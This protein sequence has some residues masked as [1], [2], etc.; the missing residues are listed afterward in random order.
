MFGEEIYYLLFVICYL[1][2]VICYLLFVKV[3]FHE[4]GQVYLCLHLLIGR[5]NQACHAGWFL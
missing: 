3:I 4:A 1:L 5:L 2:F